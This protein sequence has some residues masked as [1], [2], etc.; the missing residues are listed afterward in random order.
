MQYIMENDGENERKYPSMFCWLYHGQCKSPI[1]T[2]ETDA[3]STKM[4]PGD[5]RF[6]CFGDPF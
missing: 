3:M 6:W 2:K 1:Y 4:T 5:N